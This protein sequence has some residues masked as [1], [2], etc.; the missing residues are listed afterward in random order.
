MLG[1]RGGAAGCKSAR[2]RNAEER[3]CVLP[4]AERAVR[5]IEDGRQVDL[6]PASTERESG[7]LPRGECLPL[8][9]DAM[10]GPVGRQL[11]EGTHVPSFLV[12]EDE[13]ARRPRGAAIPVLHEHAA[14]SRGRGQAGDDHE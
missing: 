12:D 14:D 2:E 10:R 1:A 3:R 13:R 4:G 7:R 5:Q 11:G 9:P 8:A 6:N